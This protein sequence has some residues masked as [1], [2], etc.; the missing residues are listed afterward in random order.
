[1]SLYVVLF[2]EGACERVVKFVEINEAAAWSRGAYA[3]AGLYGCGSFASYILPH[4]ET[5]MVEDQDPEEVTR[6]RARIQEMK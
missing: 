5:E 4:E 3:G 2:A 6:A 1:M